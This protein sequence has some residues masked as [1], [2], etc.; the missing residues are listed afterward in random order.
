[1]IKI[2]L[3][4]FILA[5]LTFGGPA[6]AHAKLRSSA[7]TADAQ[8]IDAPKQLILIFN[9]NVQLAVLKL[10]TP[11][12]VIPLN[13]DRNAKPTEK[14]T[15]VLPRLSAGKYLVTWTAL[16]SGDGNIV[17]GA[18]SFTIKGST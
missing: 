1:M 9:E 2:G 18:F 6:L 15:V 16:S 7:P 10:S 4:A 12:K 11:A 5:C 14:V 13:I 3:P 17:R 8:L